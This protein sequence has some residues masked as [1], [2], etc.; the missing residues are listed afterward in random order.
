VRL[1]EIEKK[2]KQEKEKQNTE[3]PW[4]AYLLEYGEIKEL[5]R[6][7]IQETIKSIV[8]YGD[9]RIEITYLFGEEYDRLMQSVV[10]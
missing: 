8:V 4:I 5:T 1:E 2:K 3:A 10:D 7:I 6:E 9:K